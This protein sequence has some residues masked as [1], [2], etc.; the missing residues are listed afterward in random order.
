MTE[1]TP[2]CQRLQEDWK[3]AAE[4]YDAV[5]PNHCKICGGWGG[6]SHTENASPF[7]S[8]ENWPMTVYDECSCWE[9]AICPR[10]GNQNDDVWAEDDNPCPI[11]GWTSQDKGRPGEPECLCWMGTEDD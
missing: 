9:N 10:C 7:G 8:G 2:E 1:C 5:W 4:A 6:D 3:K 11:C